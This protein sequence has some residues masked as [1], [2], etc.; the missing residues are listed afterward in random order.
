MDLH[1]GY[2]LPG[3]HHKHL[4]EFSEQQPE[5]SLGD[6]DSPGLKYFCFVAASIGN[7]DTYFVFH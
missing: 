1:A 2:R 5:Q 3:R 7:A 6:M 4:A